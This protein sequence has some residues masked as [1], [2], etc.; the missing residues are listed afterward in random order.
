MRFHEE[1]RNRIHTNPTFVGSDGSYS[2][3]SCFL[4]LWWKKAVRSGASDRQE[5]I[6]LHSM[7]CYS[8]AE[9]SEG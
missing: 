7:E 6:A 3:Q 5:R 2:A 8:T 9:G 4:Q 1:A